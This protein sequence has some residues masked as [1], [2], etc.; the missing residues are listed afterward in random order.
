MLGF[1]RKRLLLEYLLFSAAWV[2]GLS[3]C[4]HSASTSSEEK[5]SG[6]EE[7]P[8]ITVTA[9]PAE[10]RNIGRTISLLGRCDSPPEKRALITSV[11]EAQVTSL[12]AKQGSRVMAGQAI[13]QLDTQLAK[14]DL[15]EKQAARDS[16]QASL[17]LLQ[18]P[19]REEDKRTSELAIDQA[20]LGVER[21]EAQLDRLRVL[22]DRKEIPEA[23]IYDADAALKQARMQQQ[24][25][26]AQYD[27]LVTPQRFE[28][29]AEARSKISVAEKAVDT[30]KTRLALHT[31]R[32]PIAGILNSLTCWPGQTV[33]VGAVI[34]DVVDNDQ[35][36]VAAWVPVDKSHSIHVRQ[37]AHIHSNGTGSMPPENGKAGQAPDAHVTYIG[38]SADAQS[39]NVPVQIL[40]DNRDSGL[41][42]G[43]SCNVDI[44]IAAPSH[45]LCVPLE[46][47]HDEGERPAI[48]VV[49][50][51]K[52]V[53]LHPTLGE[54]DANGV[55]VSD[56][57]L[58]EG[59]LIAVSGAY[60]LPDGTPVKA[61]VIATKAPPK[62]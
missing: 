42:I 54:R 41:V 12:L 10:F 33:S 11:V 14:A 29:V 20:K 49:R 44:D 38:V 39:G 48:T 36:I 62:P 8:A 61:E 35:V 31:I 7:A 55:A 50:E 26:Q 51:G 19:P 22:R 16:A 53:V 17:A 45:M 59:E 40:V 28:A 37:T 24:T 23:Q 15:A 2:S 21:A 56:T 46:A 47:V 3:G 4:H 60:N 30:A 58:K 6:A 25:A 52:A 32:A 34:G 27:L 43:Q 18:A 5:E 57:D 9:K 1:E 13:A